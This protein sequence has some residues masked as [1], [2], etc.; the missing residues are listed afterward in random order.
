MINIRFFATVARRI[1]GDWWYLWDR[2]GQITAVGTVWEYGFT[3]NEE[4]KIEKCGK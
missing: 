2:M 1:A 3:T 4:G